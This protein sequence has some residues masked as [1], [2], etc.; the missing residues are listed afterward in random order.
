MIGVVLHVHN[1]T[2]YEKGIN[3][4]IV[5]NERYTSQSIK[6]E[7]DKRPFITQ[8][9]KSPEVLLKLIESITKTLNATIESNEPK[10]SL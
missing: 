5:G 1:T 9:M 3:T 2:G 10:I 8:Y 6:S 7:K 4:E